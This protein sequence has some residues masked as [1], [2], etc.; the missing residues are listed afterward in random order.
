MSAF[1]PE[2]T[3]LNYLGAY[4]SIRLVNWGVV[5]EPFTKCRRYFNEPGVLGR[6]EALIVLVLAR[7]LLFILQ[8]QQ[9]PIAEEAVMRTKRYYRVSNKGGRNSGA[10]SAHSA[11]TLKTGQG[12]VLVESKLHAYKSWLG[13]ALKK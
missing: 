2:F 7:S 8:N 12:A 1:R 3:T 10:N 4:L 6:S 13:E 11:Y 9:K 5:L